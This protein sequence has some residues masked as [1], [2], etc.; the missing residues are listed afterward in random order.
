MVLLSF[1]EAYLYAEDV[2]L[3]NDGMWINE[4]C[5]NFIWRCLEVEY[6]NTGISLDIRSVVF[7]MDPTVVSYLRFQIEPEEYSDFINS[8]L[9]FEKQWIFI[10][11]NN[12]QHLLESGSH[13]S[14][15]V[16]DIRRNVAVH[17]D[18]M[19]KNNLSAAQSVVSALSKVL[20]GK[21]STSIRLINVPHEYCPQQKDGYNC[22]IYMILAADII[23]RQAMHEM[24]TY[25]A[26]I[27]GVEP[28]IACSLTAYE[29]GDSSWLQHMRKNITPAS[30]SSFRGTIRAEVKARLAAEAGKSAD[31]VI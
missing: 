25:S 28:S 18:S 6:E 23:A 11:V 16:Y 7:F 8:N 22:G 20:V 19:K 5:I 21:I 30:A 3:L 17:I 9:I 13:W 24:P 12:A 14:L 29:G 26:P 15:L 1:R 10:P 2:Q 31:S 4:A 27:S